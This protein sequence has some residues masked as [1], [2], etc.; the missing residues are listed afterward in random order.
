MNGINITA[1]GATLDK[2]CI[3][4]GLP[5]VPP[6]NYGHD[7]PGPKY[8]TMKVYE[9]IIYVMNATGYPAPPVG[10]Y[11]FSQVAVLFQRLAKH[12]LMTN[13]IPMSLIN[14]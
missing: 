9:H 12:L 11:H 14:P 7:I 8:G 4:L 13:R 10:S 3:H 6:V 1:I 2:I 5:T